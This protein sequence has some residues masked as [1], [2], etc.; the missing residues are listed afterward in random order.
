M[1][2][3]HQE[4]EWILLIYVFIPAALYVYGFLFNAPHGVSIYFSLLLLS[5]LLP[6]LFDW[7]QLLL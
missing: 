2:N 5:A 6:L 3:I 4:L 7:G 1:E